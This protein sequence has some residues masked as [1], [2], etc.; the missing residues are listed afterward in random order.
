MG[1]VKIAVGALLSLALVSSRAVASGFENTA[2]GASAQGMGGAFRAIAD[3]WT[4]AYYNPAGLAFQKDNSFGGYASFTQLRNEINPN[5]RY[6]DA[7][8]NIY[9]TGVMNDRPIYNFHQIYYTPGSGMV[10]RIPVSSS[11]V[12]LG[13]SAYQPFDYNITWQLFR[14]L[15]AYND[16]A[17][18]LYPTVQYKNNIDVVA[19]QLTAAR[20][21]HNDKLALGLGLQL[22]RGDLYYNDLIFRDNPLPAQLS[23]RPYEH[24]P[25]FMS[26]NGNGWGFGFRAGMMYKFSKGTFALTAAVPFDITIKGKARLNFLMPRNLT[27]AKSYVVGTPEY[28]F[29]TGAAVN[30][31]ADFETKLNLPASVAVAG[32]YRPTEKLT[33][34]LDA[35]LQMWSSFDGLRFDYTNPNGFPIG[36]TSPAIASFLTA[37]TVRPANWKTVGKVALGLKYDWISKLSLLAGGSLDQAANGDNQSNLPQLLDIGNKLGLNLG[38]VLHASP[39]FNCSLVLSYRHYPNLSVTGFYDLNGDGIADSFPGD[40]KA[41]TVETV[42]SFDYRF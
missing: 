40:Y 6:V 31:T 41:E 42:L 16:S 22:L 30:M 27:L 25:Q 8:G 4:A 33:V 21:F 18:G 23:D 20:T 28:L 36:G 2:V 11:E 34:A 24:I 3:D 14:P 12:V 38:G 39:R 32:S 13:L 35:E 19:F 7:Y 26:A 5:Y 1:I 15:T 37:S 9:E 29:T 10:T 17:E